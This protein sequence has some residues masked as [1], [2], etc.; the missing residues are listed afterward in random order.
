MGKIP[1]ATRKLINDY[2]SRP[3]DM[4]MGQ[5]CR[6]NKIKVYYLKRVIV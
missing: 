5:F 4:S 6:A 1:E 3:G 2:Y